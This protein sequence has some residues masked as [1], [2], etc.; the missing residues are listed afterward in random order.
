MRRQ[1]TFENEY[2]TFFGYGVGWAPEKCQLCSELLDKSKK[3]NEHC[4][5]CWKLEIF[6][7]NCTDIDAVKNYFLEEGKKDHTLH[8]KWLRGKMELPRDLMTS[9]PRDA[10]PD[11][12]VKEEAVILIYC[13]SIEERETRR[14]K[15]LDDLC[16]AGLYKKENISF[17]RGCLNFDTVIGNWKDWYD[18]DK[19]FLDTSHIDQ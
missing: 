3:P 1:Y 14:K 19:D 2:W 12:D 18:L 13:Q 9:I 16:T 11:E 17:R 15:I 8:G 7:S 4:I 6:F 10:H 5:N